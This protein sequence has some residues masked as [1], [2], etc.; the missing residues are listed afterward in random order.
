[1]NDKS[2][3]LAGSIVSIFGPIAWIGDFIVGGKKSNIIGAVLL[4]LLLTLIITGI[5]SPTAITDTNSAGGVVAVVVISG[6][7]IFG[8]YVAGLVINWTKYAQMS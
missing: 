8:C 4:A 6:L 7:G 1:M 3:V 5:A 2:N